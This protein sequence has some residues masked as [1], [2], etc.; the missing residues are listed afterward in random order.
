MSKL[1]AM[2][3][4]VSAVAFASS[5]ANAQYV[6]KQSTQT[7]A[8]VQAYWTPDKMA[9]AI[10]KDVSAVEPSSNVRQTAAPGASGAPGAAGGSLPTIKGVTDVLVQG[11]PATATPAPG[12]KRS[13]AA[14]ASTIVPADG[15]YPGPNATYEY[16]PRYRTFPVSTV[17][18]LFFTEPGNGNY[19]CTATA[20]Y[21]DASVKNM[22]WTAGH[23]VGGQGAQNFYTNFYFCPSYDSSQGGANPAVGCWSWSSA[24]L[25]T[26]WSTN[27]CW[28]KDYAYIKLASTG[29]V[30]NANVV[31]AVGGL[32]FAWNYG[33]DQH[34]H[35]Y[36]YPS[37]SPWPGGKL[38]ATTTEHRYDDS[39]DSCGPGTNAWG[40][41][42]TPGS[43]GSSLIL[44]F[45]YTGGGNYINSNVS[46]YFTAP[47]NE[48]GVMLHGPYYDTAACTFWKGG[49]GYA[50]SC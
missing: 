10:S 41:G 20:T 16:G 6:V 44:N 50:G 9:A 15:S 14:P 11:K 23:C 36:G 22:I 29:T 13:S 32:G 12:G 37:A 48:Y 25:T 5:A 2:A 46:F 49:S 1:L 43:S 34:W 4:S 42:Q 45:S 24:T 19:V 40:S 38:V 26:G 28:S 7:P 31:D 33:R 8:S 39:S 17:G 47:T 27:G 35:H 30:I 21:G 18:K 3:L